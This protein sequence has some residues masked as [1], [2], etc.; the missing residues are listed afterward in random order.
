MSVYN[1]YD[2]YVRT[3]LPIELE[4]MIAHAIV[5]FSSLIYNTYKVTNIF[6]IMVACEIVTNTS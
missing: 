2:S 3:L 6:C 1:A 4:M 5:K